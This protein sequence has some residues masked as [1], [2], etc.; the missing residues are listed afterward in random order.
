MVYFTCA[1]V[2]VSSSNFVKNSMSLLHAC[3]G[4]IDCQIT[5]A[6]VDGRFVPLVKKRQLE[7]QAE[8]LEAKKNRHP[9]RPSLEELFVSNDTNKIPDWERQ[10][11]AREAGVSEATAAR[12]QSLDNARP[13]LADMV[14]AGTLTP[15]QAIAQRRRD[16]A[17]IYQLKAE[18]K[19]G[20][21]LADKVTA[22]NPQLLQAATIGQLPDGVDKYESHRWQVEAALLFDCY[23]LFKVCQRCP[24]TNPTERKKN[25]QERPTAFFQGNRAIDTYSG[26]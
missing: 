24:L 21:W 5:G 11:L 16:E 12:A 18:R 13:D 14:I 26:L 2:I 19:A 10:A 1:G 3:G 20:E 7:G 6:V 8:W 15:A 23:Q 9:G 22:G 17:K 25:A 4:N